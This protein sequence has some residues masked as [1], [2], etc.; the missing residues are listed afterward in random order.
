MNRITV[1]WAMAKQLSG[2]AA[3]TRIAA[4]GT[5]AAIARHQDR[6]VARFLADVLPRSAH[7]QDRFAAHGAPSDWRTLPVTDKAGM[8]AHFD[9]L[10]TAG[11]RLDDALKIALAAEESRDFSAT[12][13][14]LTVGLSSGTSGNRGVFLASPDEAAQ[15]A[16][17]IL[18]KVLGPD[19]R[20][21]QRIALFLR[22]GSG[23]YGGVASKRVQFAYFDMQKPPA[24]HVEALNTLAPTALVAPASVLLMLAR[25]KQAGRLRI[26]P[27]R[28]LSVAEKLEPVDARV[29]RRAFGVTVGQIYQATEGFL[30]ASCAFGTLHLNEDL[31]AIQRAP[32]EPDAEGLPGNARFMPIITDWNRRAQP[33]VRHQL[34]DVLVP[35]AV[36]CSCGSP[37][38]ALDTIE[39]RADDVFYAPAAP[40]RSSAAVPDDAAHTGARGGLLPVFAD[41]VRRGIIVACPDVTAYGV[42]QTAPGHVELF[43]AP[44]TAQH[45]AAD[46][47]K[48]VFARAGAVAPTVKT[49]DTWQPAG[50]D[51]PLRKKKR[52]ERT[53]EVPA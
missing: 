4:L 28:V 15:W 5:R 8:M 45:R 42:R 21:K 17:T 6:R 47:V 32:L 22:A 46:A 48:A 31:V 34:D 35:R 51:D 39:G 38:L 36:P 12:L 53:F 14:G 50:H 1:L 3:R 2:H 18:A 13:D 52:V 7:L 25:E 10:N 49:L 24:A 30:G 26:A 40:A 11:V 20:K 9:T 23:L 29:I 37:L 27:R 33:M 44:H 41:Y 16:G 43:V 19:V